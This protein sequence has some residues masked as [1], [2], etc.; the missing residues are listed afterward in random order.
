[1]G[2]IKLSIGLGVFFFVVVLILVGTFFCT[3]RCLVTF[4]L[5]IVTA[6]LGLITCVLTFFQSSIQKLPGSGL[7]QIGLPATVGLTLGLLVAF[8][9]HMALPPMPEECCN[10]RC[11]I[12]EGENE[13]EDIFKK[14]IE[15]EARALM[16]NGIQQWMRQL[17]LI[18]D[19]NADVIDH[20]SSSQKQ[21]FRTHYSI[22]FERCK[23]ISIVHDTYTV[24]D[25][26]ISN[27]LFF[28]KDAFMMPDHATVETNSRVSFIEK[29]TGQQITY[30]NPAV[31][32]RWV[33]ERKN[34]CC[35]WKLVEVEFGFK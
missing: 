26:K 3:F 27:A 19:A 7:I 22:K 31:S 14:I 12:G 30:N 1:M 21:P 17:E 33:F 35:C 28:T 23:F 9:V 11:L 5:A 15:Q 32:D 24:H 25:V 10:N 18:Y 34:R 2:K 29:S 16:Q 13:H 20:Y 8:G 6:M 4:E